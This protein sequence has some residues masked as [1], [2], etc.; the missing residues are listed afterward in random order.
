MNS[1]QIIDEILRL[2]DLQT[3]DFVDKVQER[4]KKEAV[5]IATKYDLK[6]SFIQIVL[7]YEGDKDKQNSLSH[8][9][10][11]FGEMLK[12]RKDFL[13]LFAQYL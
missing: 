5:L 6:H 9:V 11:A 8:M 3:S 7:T 4:N 10:K 13:D 2:K 1:T 12:K